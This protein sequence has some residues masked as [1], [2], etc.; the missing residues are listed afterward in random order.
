MTGMQVSQETQNVFWK[1]KGSPR[2]ALREFRAIF[3]QKMREGDKVGAHMALVSPHYSLVKRYWWFPPLAVWHMQRALTH[4]MYVYQVA[5]LLKRTAN[6]LDVLSRVFLNVPSWLGGSTILALEC[7]NAGLS[8]VHPESETMAPH[9]KAF[10]W[11]TK[12]DIFRRVGN[13][14][15]ARESYRVAENFILLI[16]KNEPHEHGQQQLCRVLGSIGLGL[17]D[18]HI[19]HQTRCVGRDYVQS[20]MTLAQ[21]VARDQYLK[22]ERASKKRKMF[23]M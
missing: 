19:D 16:K 13:K 6:E 8:T 18:L 12:A 14:R 21:Q 20:A 17:W 1:R 15:D 2:K 9:T 4:A 7:V 11:I 22:F 23:K 5:P 3:R 10:F